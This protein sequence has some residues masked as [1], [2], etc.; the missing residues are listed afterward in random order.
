MITC[1]MMQKLASNFLLKQIFGVAYCCF[2]SILD[3]DKMLSAVFASVRSVDFHDFSNGLNRNI[4]WSCLALE[5]QQVRPVLHCLITSAFNFTCNYFN[6]KSSP[7]ESFYHWPMGSCRK[8]IN[9]S[10]TQSNTR[11]LQRE[12]AVDF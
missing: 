4:Q 8:P 9:I 3:Q 5:T 6:S 10:R 2:L 12:K 11:L 1:F 7:F